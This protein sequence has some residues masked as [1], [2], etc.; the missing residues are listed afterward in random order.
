MSE[1]TSKML[2]KMMA[3]STRDKEYWNSLSH[4]ERGRISAA[5]RDDTKAAPINFI[6]QHR[7]AA[8]Q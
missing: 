7:V 2:R 6:A 4:T 3:A 1:K 8:Q 5:Y